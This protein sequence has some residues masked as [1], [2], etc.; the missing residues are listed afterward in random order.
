MKKLIFFML[1]ISNNL[2]AQLNEVAK[3]E[4]IDFN[5][6]II[7]M[8]SFP[9]EDGLLNASL[10]QKTY[11]NSW[12]I[13]NK[14]D[15]SLE[16]TL[17]RDSIEVENT[18]QEFIFAENKTKSFWLI[19]E[20]DFPNFKIICLDKKNGQL[21]IMFGKLPSEFDITTFKV[22]ENK[23][24]LIGEKY[25]K[26]IIANFSFETFK[27]TFLNDIYKDNAVINN[28][29][30]EDSS[31]IIHVLLN[32]INSKNCGLIMKNYD[33]Q[34]QLINSNLL[35][36]IETIRN[37]QKLVFV[38]GQLIKTSENKS[39]LVGNYSKGCSDYSKGIYITMIE[40]NE[41][42][43]SKMIPFTHFS[44][45]FSH[46]STKKQVR[47]KNKIVNKQTN[48]KE[49]EYVYRLNIKDAIA[50]NNGFVLEAEVYT[51]QSPSPMSTSPINIISKTA[52]I[53]SHAIIC[54]FNNEGELLWDN[55]MNLNDFE[56]YQLQNIVQ[57]IN[58][59]ENWLMAYVDNNEIIYKIIN[60][61]KFSPTTE[62][63]ELKTN[64]ITPE[65]LHLNSW[66]N[67]LLATGIL[68]DKV[69]NKG[70]YHDIYF[71]T[72]IGLIKKKYH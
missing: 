44:N 31:D 36:E 49:I 45:F 30:T 63:I 66:N 52:Y 41:E 21:E 69:N 47:I 4:I 65:N 26:S 43:W 2:L 60:K 15:L 23:A 27:T 64:K 16:K 25:G 37:E 70:K 20:N 11:N 71:I 42:I 67:H 72:K 68:R 14:Y 13:F 54:G 7:W 29:C 5:N 39:I 1:I 46:F 12:L 33:E 59:E 34:S 32:E 62:K 38:S 18:I 9:L 3:I 58:T 17:W 24:L 35:P 53:L 28:V 56:T 6:K 57:L 22:S 8:N 61:N 55:S 10:V 19:V 40:N 51:L 48:G 50:T